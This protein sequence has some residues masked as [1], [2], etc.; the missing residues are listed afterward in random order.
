MPSKIPEGYH[1][2]TPSLVVRGGAKAIDFYRRAFGAVEISRMDAPGGR[3]AHAEMKIGDSVFMLSDEFPG[4]PSPQSL[5]GSPV[6][7]FVYVHDVD[8]SF[9]Q[10]VGAGAQ[11]TMPPTDMFWGD[12]YGKLTDPFGH[13]WGLATHIKDVTPEEMKK[14]AEAMFAQMQTQH[15]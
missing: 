7:L 4:F 5:G 9:K 2:I 11:S 6:S 13:S 12:R 14:G 8:A 15:G 1:S 10:A 3:L